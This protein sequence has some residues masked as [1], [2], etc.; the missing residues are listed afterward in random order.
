MAWESENTI[1]GGSMMGKQG[2]GKHPRANAVARIEMKKICI[3]TAQV[4]LGPTVLKW[5]IVL[6]MAKMV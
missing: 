2:G 1:V 6:P 5:R 4:A 3:R